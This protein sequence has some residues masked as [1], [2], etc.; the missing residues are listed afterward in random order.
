M[1]ICCYDRA[2]KKKSATVEVLWCKRWCKVTEVPVGL[3]PFAKVLS[4]S[5]GISSHAWEFTKNLCYSRVRL[6]QH[7]TC[8]CSSSESE[9]HYDWQSVSQSVLVSYPI[10]GIWPE[11]WFFWFK[12]RKLQSCLCGHPLWREVG[13]V[14]CHSQSLSQLSVCTYISKKRKERKGKKMYR[15]WKCF[16]YNMY[17]ASVSP[18]SV[19]QCSS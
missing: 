9:S 11:T 3:L 10:W 19:Q 13:S 17:K 5:N 8:I 15:N 2:F 14:F 4:R 12:F 18:G 16:I 6:P 1:L 7:S